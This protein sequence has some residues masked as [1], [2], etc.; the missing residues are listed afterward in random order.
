MKAFIISSA[1]I[2]VVCGSGVCRAQQDGST[3]YAIPLTGVQIDGS[4]D[5][6]PQG[7]IEYRI[8][9]HG[10]VYGPTDI[11][12]QDLATSADLSPS[13]MVGFGAEESLL[14][15]A[16]RVRDESLFVRSADPW[17]TDACE[18]FVNG[19]HDDGT[20]LQYV[21]CPP[22]GSYGATLK[23]EDPSANPNLGNGDMT[24]V[25]TE[26]KVAREGDVTTYEWAIEVFDQYP[27]TS[28]VLAVGKAI[29]LDV[30]AVDKDSESD[31]PAW[32]CWGPFGV[33][34]DLN[35]EMLGDLVFIESYELLGTITGQV[36][37]QHDGSPWPGIE[38]RVENE[39][40]ETWGTA[41][42]AA[43]GRYRVRVMAGAYQVSVSPADEADPVAADVEAGGVATN[44]DLAPSL[45][46][47]SGQVTRPDGT[48]Q[49]TVRVLVEAQE[50]ETQRKGT[51]DASGRYSVWVPPGAYRVSVVDAE[52][53]DPVA[54]SLEA[55]EQV[56]GIDFTPEQIGQTLPTWPLTT[57]LALF[58]V[59]ILACLAP[60]YKRRE[61]LGGVILS[62]GDTF[63]ELAEEPDWV[64]P[65]FMV[66]VASLLLVVSGLGKLFTGPGG[67]AGGMPG[68]MQIM[69]MVVMPLFSTIAVL[70]VA[71]LSWLIRAM[72][73]WVL[74]RISGDRVALFPLI[75]V[76]GYAFL[77]ELLLAGVVMA[78]AISF[79]GAETMS[80]WGGMVTSLAGLYPGLAAGDAPLRSLL[81]EIELLS[82][83]SLALTIV[84]VQRV[85][86]FSMRKAA[87]IGVLYWLLAVGATVGF[88]AL[89]D[90]F[91]QMMDGA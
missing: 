15:L 13:F 31:R 1:L 81:G 5:D 89:T 41:V 6:W 21:M 48:P 16:V 44:T 45:A 90:V 9:N 33:R 59:A 14:Y 56:E 34:K 53:T 66:P 57:G 11:D 28:T 26:A 17:H 64:G 38:V 82:F 60:L 77:P 50:G 62:P 52:E 86:G 47:I 8:R 83:W 73:I 55:G 36:T 54:V 71:Y 58:G 29:G 74:A 69:M 19:R 68:N 2:L 22:G 85:Y 76:V 18:V 61:R 24:R 80:A 10:Q 23:G 43:D 63:R 27:D 78:V 32:I 88:A 20:V 46:T 7:M 4:L 12:T 67:F 65:F 75:S 42:T 70:V 91:K 39:E 87:C 79:G 35:A 3:A 40:G 30:V 37:R 49:A 25:R 72:A 84:G 51:T